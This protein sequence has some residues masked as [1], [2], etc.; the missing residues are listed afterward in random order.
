MLANRHIRKNSYKMHFSKKRKNIGRPVIIGFKILAGVFL[1][2]MLSAVYIFLYSFITQCDYF[3]A[4]DI[5]ITGINRLSEE[6]I[7][8]QAK[9][10]T[11]I[12]I[13]SI[14]LSS[15]RKRLLSHP[16][17]AKAD[18]VRTLP[19]KL[20]IEIEEH[21]PLAVLDLGKKFLMDENGEIYK[22]AS[23]KDLQQLPVISG[24][25]FS[26]IGPGFKCMGD[27]Y[28]AVMNVLNLGK[29]PCSILPNKMIKL[30]HVDREIGI[31]LFVDEKVGA[32][33]IKLGYGDYKDK[34]LKLKEVTLYMKNSYN[35]NFFDSID[36]VNAGRIVVN[37]IGEPSD[38][39]SGK[40]V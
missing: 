20:K 10:F 6:I 31:T 38:T 12:N 32:R 37:P 33:T 4:K 35:V 30:I 15:S 39:L 34:Y 19:D 5:E 8:E 22:G 7:L 9:I 1:V 13:L 17:I 29:N 11:G 27:P 28:S 24:L 36:M 2:M 14:N 25:Q 3:K 40:E 26:D 21:Q 18:I 16:D 23:E